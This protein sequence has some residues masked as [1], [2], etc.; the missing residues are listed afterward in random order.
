M[1]TVALRSGIALRAGLVLAIFT[2]LPPNV[3]SGIAC[4]E[5]PQD[6]RSR[7]FL[8]H[9]DLPKKDADE[10]LKKM[11]IMLKMISRYWGAPLRKPVECYVVVNGKNWP[12]ASLP[13]EAR[14]IV[15]NGGITVAQG[16]RRGNVFNLTATVF[17]SSKYG[18]AQHEA[19]HAYCYHTFGVTG[20]TWYAEGMA[21][22][23]NYWDEEDSSVTAP[24]Y[25]VQFLKRSQKKSLR[26]IT[27][28][29]DRTGDGWQNYA[30]RWAL[31]HFLVNNPNYRDRFRQLGVSFLK[32]RPTS[33]ERAYASQMQELEFEFDLFVEHLDV[34]LNAETTAWNWKTRPRE[35]SA[36]RTM[37]TKVY[38]QRGWQPT[39]A[40]VSQG[41][42]YALEIEGKWYVKPGEEVSVAGND[43]GKG[44]LIAAIMSDMKLSE[45]FEIGESTKLVAPGSGQLVLR[46]RDEWTQLNDNS[47]SITVKLSAIE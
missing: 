31:C 26:Q 23:G 17:A 4:A 8:I 34:G 30:W 25:V 5:E 27:D 3:F 14:S 45:P 47:G 12:A 39:N 9:T 32:Q 20:P 24:D 18:T 16:T 29:N 44:K 6:F 42:E 40:L 10:L 41:V 7:N 28:G 13:A 21:E 11:E 35:P 33:F 15:Q 38:A 22:M 2:L 19:V 37:T 1:L 36:K 46:C 43:Q